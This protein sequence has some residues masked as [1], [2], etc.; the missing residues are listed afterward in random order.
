MNPDFS[1]ITPSYNGLTHL[2]RAV[3]SVRDQ[4]GL[5]VQ[6]VIVDAESS[7]GTPEWLAQQPGLQSIIEKDEGMYDAINKGLNAATGQYVA[8]L[9]CDEQYLSDTLSIVKNYFESHPDVDVAYGDCL[10]TRSSGEL[11]AYRRAYPLRYA[12]VAAWQLYIMTASIFYRRRVIDDGIRFDKRFR[13]SGDCE[14]ILR[15]LKNGYKPGRISR[16]LSCFAIT[17]KN[18]SGGRKSDTE[19]MLER[20]MVPAWVRW[21]RYPINALRMTE[22]VLAGAYRRT[23]LTYACYTN[24]NLVHRTEFRVERPPYQWPQW[25]AV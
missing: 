7:D 14:F 25:D 17:G 18:L 21:F 5:K 24:D 3:A 10:I 2:K 15:L 6:H 22:K 11:L 20:Q 12:Y 16:P 4:K 8:Y 13:I 1:I 9:N 23:P 19:L